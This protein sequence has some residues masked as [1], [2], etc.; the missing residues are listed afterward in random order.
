MGEYAAAPGGAFTAAIDAVREN[1]PGAMGRLLGDSRG[2]R[3]ER[4]L[5]I[6]RDLAGERTAAGSRSSRQ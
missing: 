4:V 2:R 1:S 5:E 3:V 6:A